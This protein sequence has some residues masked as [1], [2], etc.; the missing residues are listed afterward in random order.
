MFQFREKF[1][2]SEQQRRRVKRLKFYRTEERE[3]F[4]LM[5]KRDFPTFNIEPFL[6]SKSFGEWID[7]EDTTKKKPKGKKVFKID[8]EFLRQITLSQTPT[9]SQLEDMSS[10]ERDEYI[11][12]RESEY[13]EEG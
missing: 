7:V 5:L 10:N 11:Q 6:D 8:R 13:S 4:L 2:T 12:Q 1:K 9:L 3:D